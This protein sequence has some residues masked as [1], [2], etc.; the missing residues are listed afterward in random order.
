MA[1]CQPTV[2]LKQH[3]MKVKTHGS[4]GTHIKCINKDYLLV[5]SF[6]NIIWISLKRVKQ[7]SHTEI[8]HFSKFQ[9]K[10]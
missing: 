8:L 5:I 3:N 2:Y 4:N 7:L 1:T 6:L 10:I 9:F